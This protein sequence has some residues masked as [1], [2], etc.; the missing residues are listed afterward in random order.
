MTPEQLKRRREY[1]R[2]RAARLKEAYQR[3]NPG[4]VPLPMVTIWKKEEG[5][6]MIA[7][8]LSDLVCRAFKRGLSMEDVARVFRVPLSAVHKIIREAL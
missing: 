6:G 4:R 1:G 3:R 5:D 8:E 7:K 2:K